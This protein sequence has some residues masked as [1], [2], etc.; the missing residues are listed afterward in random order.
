MA[1]RASCFLLL[2]PALLC[3]L[4][5][6]CVADSILYSGSSLYTGQS[7]N[8]GSYY[9]TMQSDCNLVL[10]D[11]GRALWATNTDGRGSNCRAAMQKDGNFVVYNGNNNAVWASGSNRG[12]GNYILILQRDRNVVIYGGS[13]WAS[14]S[15]AYGTGVT[16]SGAPAAVND[17]ISAPASVA[18]RELDLG[19]KISL[20]TNRA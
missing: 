20:V 14:G 8:Y 12:N 16:I 3:L 4:S 19:R 10:Y 13:I 17:D 1:S 15:N 6:P 18:G 5:S 2:A 11:A 7:L 9:L